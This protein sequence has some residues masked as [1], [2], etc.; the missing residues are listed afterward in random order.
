MDKLTK[1]QVGYH[2]QVKYVMNAS[3]NKNKI[4]S[5]SKLQ[6]LKPTRKLRGESGWVRRSHVACSFVGSA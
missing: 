3:Q 2:E 6:S 4:K 1:Y 5:T